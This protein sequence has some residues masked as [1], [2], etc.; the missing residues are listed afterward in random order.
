LCNNFNDALIYLPFCSFKCS[1]SV[2]LYIISLEVARE[3]SHFCKM[4]LR[5]KVVGSRW[6]LE[7]NPFPAKNQTLRSYRVYISPNE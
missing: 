2:V 7:R 5:L 3:L 4:A 1:E 6:S